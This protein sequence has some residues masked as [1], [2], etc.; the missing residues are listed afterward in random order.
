[1]A[2]EWQLELA[3]ANAPVVVEVVANPGIKQR[4]KT[5]AADLASLAEIAPNQVLE[6]WSKH[7]TAERQSR[8]GILKSAS[9]LAKIRVSRVER[10]R[11]RFVIVQDPADLLLPFQHQLESPVRACQEEVV[12]PA[13]RHARI[14]QAGSHIG[15]GEHFL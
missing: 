12:A 9:C 6:I 8:P 2:V 13:G 7:V 14:E 3:D 11:D 1:F 5:A 15:I 10:R 4:I